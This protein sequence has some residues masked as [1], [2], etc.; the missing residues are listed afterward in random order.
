VLRFTK[1]EHTE[2]S[3]MCLASCVGEHGAVG[4][5]DEKTC[6]VTAGPVQK[7]EYEVNNGVSLC[8]LFS[9]LTPNDL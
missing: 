2:D 8:A 7:A 3:G 5:K 1:L 6:E 9:P 4:I